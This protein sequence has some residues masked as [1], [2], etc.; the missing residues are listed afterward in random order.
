MSLR[1]PNL[2]L[3]KSCWHGVLVWWTKETFPKGDAL[4]IAKRKP[5]IKAICGGTEDARSLTQME[6]SARRLMAD[7]NT[8][9]DGRDLLDH[10][11]KSRLVTDWRARYGSLFN[12]MPFSVVGKVGVAETRGA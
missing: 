12:T 8:R 6:H 5:C 10:H 9:M 7:A 1:F 2:A 4:K 3:C 11:D